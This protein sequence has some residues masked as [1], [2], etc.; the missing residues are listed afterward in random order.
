MMLLSRAHYALRSPLVTAHGAINNREALL[1]GAQDGA[2]IG[3]AEYSPLPGFG[4][5]M[6]LD[7]VAAEISAGLITPTVEW[8]QADLAAR[9]SGRWLA[10]LFGASTVNPSI[11]V[12]ATIG[13]LSA[14]ET[15]QRCRQIAAEGYTAVKLKVAAGDVERDIGRVEAARTALGPTIELRLDANQGWNLGQAH[16]ALSRLGQFGVAFVEEPTADTDDMAELSAHGVGLALDESLTSG[17]ALELV[18]GSPASVVVLK[19]AVV[20]GPAAALELVGLAEAAGKRVVVTSFFDGPI[21]LSTA[22]HLAA[23]LDAHGPHGV[24]TAG[25]VDAAYPPELIAKDGKVT[26]PDAPGIGIE[27]AI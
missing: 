20:G 26:L 19:P 14:Q 16:L 6:D 2:V 25:Q 24:G 13:D 3:W 23:T 15:G 12:N 11:P 7:R 21:G 22:C 18:A 9:T 4:M 1:V 8:A 10:E 27:V 5:R 17:S